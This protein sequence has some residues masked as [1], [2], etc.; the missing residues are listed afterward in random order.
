MNTHKESR[1]DKKIK[2][3]Y[4]IDWFNKKL[5]RCK[6][7]V[8]VDKDGDFEIKRG[9]KWDMMWSEDIEDLWIPTQEELKKLLK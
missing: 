2:T 3:N 7:I 1:K 6:K 5:N 9:S 4:Q 8:R